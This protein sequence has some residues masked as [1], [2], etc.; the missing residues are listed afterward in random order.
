M[1]DV[2]SFDVVIIG[3]GVIGCSIAF[4][5]AA[6]KLNVVVL[7]RDEPA[8]G[9]SWAAAGMLAPGPDSPESLPLVPF[10]K[11]SLRLYP[12]FIAALEE[13][14]GLSAAFARE[15][16][17]AAFFAPGGERERDQMVAEYRRLGI[18]IEPIP[19]G[20][21]REMEKGL[22]YAAA[23][24]AWLP[25]EATVDPRSLMSALLSAIRRRNIEIR[26][27]CDVTSLLCEKGRCTGVVAGG[28]RILAKTV[29]VAAGC[30]SATITNE[31]TTGGNW[32]ARYAP[33]HPVRGQMVA[34]R[35]SGISLRRVS[36]SER[37]YL[38]PRPDGR[39]IA[40]ST[41]EDAGFENRV[42]PAGMRKILD[43]ALELAP[44]LADAEISETWSGLR[45]GTPDQLPILGP[46][47]I[48]GLLIATGHYRNGILLAPATAKLLRECIVNGKIASNA[49]AFSPMRFS[50]AKSQTAH[51]K[52]ATALS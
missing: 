20:T 46:T 48:E 21:A 12:E 3:G 32:L 43:A 31:N 10:A 15:G 19:L 4:E 33:T 1:G 2:S 13:T 28:E 41:L 22:G 40:G 30:Y 36:R 29:V 39:I 44:G 17:L 50:A 49:Q 25:D 37:G 52:R 42:T 38:V 47:D 7:D 27:G 16:T 18:P 11:E 34:L 51:S 5:L 26:P 45:P 8:R 14:S 9:A 24:V 35:T 23:A 6:E